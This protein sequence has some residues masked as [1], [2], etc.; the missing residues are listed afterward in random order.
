MSSPAGDGTGDDPDDGE[1]SG[2]T[3]TPTDTPTATETQT[4]VPAELDVSVTSLAPAVVEMS[5][6]DSITVGNAIGSQFLTLHVA[7]E[8]GDP[9]AADDLRVRFD[10]EAYPP[11]ST[12][13]ASADRRLWRAYR[14]RDGGYPGLRGDGWLVYELPATGDASA[15]ALTWPDGGEWPLDGESA[16]G[17][18]L[19]T[20]LERQPPPL[21]MAFSAPKTAT[22]ESTP[23]VSFEVTNEGEV[24]GRF[25]AGL[26]RSGPRIAYTPVE[27][28]SQ[29]VAAGE[30]ATETVT[31]RIRLEDPGEDVGD[32]EPDFTYHASW[33][34]GTARRDV[35]LVEPGSNG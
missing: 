14:D 35:R 2:P 13:L 27:A 5:S 23:T 12:D 18:P 7:V 26:S 30:T 4:P 16:T 29:P 6:P 20:R 31:D 33:I 25:V 11:L 24:G 3:T 17:D 34:G 1:T 10:G 15:A 8:Y 32:D 28:V 21:S 19:R 9:P 22:P